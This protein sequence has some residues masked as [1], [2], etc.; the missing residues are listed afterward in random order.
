MATARNLLGEQPEARLR[1]WLHNG[2]DTLEELN[3][4]LVA[5]CKYYKI[6]QE[7]LEGWF[8]MT[9]GNEVPLKVANG[10]SDLK[11]DQVLIKCIEGEIAATASTSCCSI[12][13]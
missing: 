2:E 5:I 12:L 6:P 13:S 11:I 3:R 10:Y 7:E 9:S 1:V 8:F 4:R